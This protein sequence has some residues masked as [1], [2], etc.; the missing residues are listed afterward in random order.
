MPGPAYDAA[1]VRRAADRVDRVLVGDEIASARRRRSAPPRP[2][3]RTRTCSRALRARARSRAPPSIVR[4]VTNCRPRRRIARSTPLRISGSPPLR[5]SD[6]Q[7]LL[8][9]AVAARV[10]EL[11]GDEQAP[12][13]GVDEQR[14]RLRR[15]ASTSRPA[16]LVA[17]QPVARRRVGNA[18]QRLGEAHERDALAAD[19]ARTRASAR[20]RRPPCWRSARTAC[21]QVS[22]PAPDAVRN[23]VLRQGRPPR[24]AARPLAPRDGSRP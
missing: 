3:C 23:V 6:A 21:G 8:E 13:R 18:Q 7:R 17:D 4:P 11:A 2:A 1:P 19:R 22:P 12:R 5:S 15:R 9:R 10:D 24:R 16:D 14:R 20:R